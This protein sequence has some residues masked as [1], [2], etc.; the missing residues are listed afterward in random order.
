MIQSF[1]QRHGYSES[2][3][4]L[5][6]E[7][8]TPK[9]RNRL[10]NVLCLHG[11]QESSINYLFEIICGLW[12][13]YFML[14]ID[15]IPHNDRDKVVKFKEYILKCKWFEIFDFIESLNKKMSL[16]AVYKEVFRNSNFRDSINK[17]LGEE[18]S[19]YRFVDDLIV[20]ITSETEITAIE[21][22]IKDTNPYSGVKEHL[23]RSLELLS[24]REKPDYRN[25]IKESI[26]AVE[27]IS[28]TIIRDSKKTLGQAL[29]TLESKGVIAPMLKVSWE[30]LYTWTNQEEGVRHKAVVLPKVTYSDAKYMLVNCSSFVNYLIA[31]CS[32]LEVSF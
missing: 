10:W 8:C 18:N 32:E 27:S 24:D 5:E 11:F 31:K 16:S 14:P 30:K 7:N 12:D 3:S 20:E 13:D 9:L 28:C 21:T 19:A 23:H 26:S 4:S 29:N 17:V 25:S 22:A 1:S 15:E 2:S 6:R